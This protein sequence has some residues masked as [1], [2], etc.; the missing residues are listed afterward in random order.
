M[1]RVDDAIRKY[2]PDMIYFDEHAGD[3]QVDLGINMGLGRLTTRILA[4][5]YNIASKRTEGNTRVVAT[6]KGV[7]GRY[8]SFQRSPEL[9]PLVDRADHQVMPAGVRLLFVEYRK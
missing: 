4:N 7:G 6:M 8:D 3:S 2:Q 1:W 5:F 9:L